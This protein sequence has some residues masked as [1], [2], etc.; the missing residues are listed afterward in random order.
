MSASAEDAQEMAAHMRAIIS[1]RNAEAA[2]TVRILYGGSVTA[3]NAATFVGQPDVD[4]L[5]VG[6]ASLRLESFLAIADAC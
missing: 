6:G 2:E 3:D 5:L 4:G 1:E